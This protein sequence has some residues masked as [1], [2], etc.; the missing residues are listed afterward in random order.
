MYIVME[1]QKT[2]NTAADVTRIVT[3]H[4]TKN[5]AESKFHTVLA[6]AAISAVPVHSA[7]MLTDT[8][9]WLRSE[10]YDHPIAPTP[11]PED[12]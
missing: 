10:S 5:D 1:I 3:V 4:E 7:V 2:G 12:E 6:Y 11:E 9:I 8:G